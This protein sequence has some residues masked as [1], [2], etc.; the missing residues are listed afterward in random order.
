M[1]EETPTTIHYIDS[2]EY[3]NVYGVST[4]IIILLLLWYFIRTNLE[5]NDGTCVHRHRIEG[6]TTEDPA[7]LAF[8]PEF[9]PD[10]G[11][12]PIQLTPLNE[13]KPY[14]FWTGTYGDVPLSLYDVKDVAYKPEWDHKTTIYI[15]NMRT[16]F[17]N[18][19]TPIEASFW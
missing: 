1:S 9:Q 13:P 6:L 7:I 2:S 11:T 19:Y 12:I 10:Y 3:Y 17:R 14:K 4:L 18:T 5:E 15:P 8:M 16:I